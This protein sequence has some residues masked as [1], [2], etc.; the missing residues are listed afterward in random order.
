MRAKKERPPGGNQDG[1]SDSHCEGDV[2]NHP[3]GNGTTET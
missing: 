1:G 3:R 2:E